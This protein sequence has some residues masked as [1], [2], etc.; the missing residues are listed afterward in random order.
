MK[1]NNANISPKLFNIMIYTYDSD[2]FN[3]LVSQMRTPLAACRETAGKLWQ[4][5]KML[6]VFE[7][8][9]QYILIH[10]PYARI[11][12]FWH[13]SNIPRMISESQICFNTATLCTISLFVKYYYT[14]GSWLL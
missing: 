8:K 12:E 13:I 6:Y 2:R 3:R 4:L 7:H 9:A 1:N 14:T 10:V 11:V 5:C